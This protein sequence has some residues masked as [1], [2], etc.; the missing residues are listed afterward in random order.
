MS[1]KSFDKHGWL[2]DIA[3]ILNRKLPSL[4]KNSLPFCSTGLG[5]FFSVCAMCS[6]SSSVRI[7]P[8]HSSSNS[9]SLMS[10]SA[11]ESGC[12]CKAGVTFCSA[13]SCD[14]TML[15]L[16]DTSPV[17]VSLTASAPVFPEGRTAGV[18]VFGSLD[19]SVL[20]SLRDCGPVLANTFESCLSFRTADE[21]NLLRR[22]L[23]MTSGLTEKPSANL[24][25]VHSSGD[26][27]FKYLQKEGQAD[28]YKMFG[29]I[30]HYI[31]PN[32]K[33]LNW[34]VYLKYQ[35]HSGHSK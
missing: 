11:V 22:T 35:L 15:P 14:G 26:S 13:D 2:G 24:S 25:S 21:V 18:A 28:N 32:P 34:S 16:E 30:F 6:S 31:Q 19:C 12:S 4:S 23:E 5:F 20:P 8:S 1:N 27:C 17:S 7:T 9:I 10:I 33:L 3:Q 29:K